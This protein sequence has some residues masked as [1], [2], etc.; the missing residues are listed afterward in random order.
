MCFVTVLNIPDVR[1]VLN[2]IHSTLRRSRRVPEPLHV[3]RRVAN[4]IPVHIGKLPRAHVVSSLPDRT[5]RPRR[6]GRAE[7]QGA[8]TSLAPTVRPPLGGRPGAGSGFAGT[9]TGRRR[10]R[11]LS[12]L[13]RERVCARQDWRQA[14]FDEW[15]NA[16]ALHDFEMKAAQYIVKFIR[17]ASVGE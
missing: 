8:A 1:F 16:T 2:T 10:V 17:V 13:P 5:P 15:Y 4:P 7:R 3:T 6:R 11:P 12:R 14:L 9:L